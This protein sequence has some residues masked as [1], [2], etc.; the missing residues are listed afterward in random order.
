[1]PATASAALGAIGSDT[2]P[3]LLL[4]Q[5]IVPL[6]DRVGRGPSFGGKDGNDPAGQT[7]PDQ[8]S[9]GPGMPA[10]SR[11]AHVVVHL[12]KLGSPMPLPV[13]RDKGQNTMGAAVRLRASG[14]Q[15]RGDVL[16][17][18]NDDWTP[19]RQIVSHDKVDLMDVV[20]PSGLRKRQHGP[21]P[22][23]IPTFS[24]Q[25]PV[26]NQ[27]A[28][29]GPET[30]QGGDA[31]IDELLIDCFGT[32]ESQRIA[33][34]LEL[35]MDLNHQTLEGRTD[36]SSQDMGTM[37]PVLIPQRSAQFVPLCPPVYPWAAVPQYTGDP[38]DGLFLQPQAD[39]S[40]SYFDRSGS[41]FD[42]YVYPPHLTEGLYP[43]KCN[44]SVG[45]FTVTHQLA[46]D[47]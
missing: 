4:P 33:S 19:R 15:T 3:D 6:D 7:E 9:E 46:C 32:A 34:A 42:S 13:R 25:K 30:V 10:A 18:E 23:S 31:Q 5:P 38:T 16:A 17:V 37:R 29:D 8:L 2:L 12:Q 41:F 45:S 47:H 39:A 43:E 26:S 22:R 36:P 24:R 44:G 1:M 11:Q 27:D 28:M 35:A 14:H 21:S 20:L 40:F